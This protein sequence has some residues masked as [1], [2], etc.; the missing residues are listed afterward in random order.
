[1]TENDVV[2]GGDGSD[3]INYEGESARVEVNLGTCC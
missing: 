1:M 2:D 3:T